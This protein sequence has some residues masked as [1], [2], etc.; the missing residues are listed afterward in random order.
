MTKRIEIEVPE[1]AKWKAQDQYGVW[2][3]FSDRPFIGRLSHEWITRDPGDMKMSIGVG[4]RIPNWRD[5]IEEI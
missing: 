2:F 1:W 4:D 3:I 5:T